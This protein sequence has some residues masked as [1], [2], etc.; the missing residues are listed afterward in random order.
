MQIIGVEGHNPSGHCL[1][2]TR[3]VDSIPMNLHDK[4]FGAEVPQAKRQAIDTSMPMST[5]NSS[6]DL[7]MSMV[8]W[9]K[10]IF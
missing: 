1:V 6:T 4:I 8:W 5:D 10:L 9:S 2:V 7:P 3:I